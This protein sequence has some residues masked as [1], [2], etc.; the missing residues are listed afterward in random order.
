MK[1]LQHST[2]KFKFQI[3]K[4]VFFNMWEIKVWGGKKV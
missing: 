4:I 1:L 3:L 2:F